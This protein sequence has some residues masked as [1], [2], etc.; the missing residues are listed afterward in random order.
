M[1]HIRV[2][3]THLKITVK[4][5]NFEIF[6]HLVMHGARRG[7]LRGHSVTGV[8]IQWVSYHLQTPDVHLGPVFV[9]VVE[10]FWRGKLRTTTMGSQQFAIFVSITQTKICKCKQHRRVRQYSRS[11]QYGV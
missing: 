2:N 8:T 3:G 10:Q 1:Q 5:V 9:F 6:L 7:G 4:L 11:Q